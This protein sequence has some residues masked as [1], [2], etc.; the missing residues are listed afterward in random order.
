VI[1]SAA[2]TR[3]AMKWARHS[4]SWGVHDFAHLPIYF[5]EQ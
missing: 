1:M 3:A 4:L 2:L 5:L